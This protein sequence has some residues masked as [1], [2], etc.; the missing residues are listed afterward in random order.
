MTE[1]EA[2]GKWCPF[3]RGEVA[4]LKNWE[5]VKQALFIGNRMNDNVPA[6]TLC[7]GSDCMAWRKRPTT[8]IG[9]AAEGWCALMGGP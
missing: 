8:R 3:A 1:E 5:G 4:H 6:S 7:I 2:R 9:R